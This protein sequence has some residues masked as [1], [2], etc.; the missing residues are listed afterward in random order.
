MDFWS[1]R[2]RKILAL[3]T[4]VALAFLLIL[5]VRWI[6]RAAKFEEEIFNQRVA[7]ALK[8]ARD[9]I[10]ARLH[11]GN[12]MNDY[13][14]GKATSSHDSTITAQ[15]DSII[16]SHLRIN[17]IHLRYSFHL[18]GNFRTTSM[19]DD[20]GCYCQTLDGII[21][22][23]DV[24]IKVQFPDRSR[25]I[26]RQ[27]GGMFVVSVLFIIFLAISF[28]IIV[29]L[30]NRE[31]LVAERTVG[32]VNN[33]VHEFNTP[34][35]NI[36]LAAAL[37]KKKNGS[38]TRLDDYLNIIHKEHNKLV[39]HVDDI[40]NAASP[41]TI[42]GGSEKVDLLELTSGITD[43]YT[44][45]ISTRGGSITFTHGDD[46]YFVLGSF[47]QLEIVWMNLIDNAIKYSAGAPVIN[48]TLERH[49]RNSRFIVEDKGM[50]I[51]RTDLKHIFDQY[52]RVA[53]GDV[54]KIKGFGLGLYF[55]RSV[56]E[57]MGGKISAESTLGK[58]SRFIVELKQYD[59]N[60]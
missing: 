22:I 54:H 14:C 13:L 38:D 60:E 53:S 28:I 52:Y 46:S 41:K 57:G 3:L 7:I 29:R 39:R 4:F 51:P 37:I 12:P 25:Y 31:R 33:M 10:E 50:G 1:Y 5:H 2:R 6:F 23:D 48:L 26:V 30:Y 27:I 45:A 49:N 47:R 18:D 55:V 32:F 42:N 17:N 16:D 56:I 59:G 34:L 8:E 44:A 24:N 11:N 21:P 15:L 35:S 58:G 36:R 40:L 19:R 43:Y 20:A 9:E